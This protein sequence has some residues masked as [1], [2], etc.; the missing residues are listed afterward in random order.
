MGVLN[1]LGSSSQIY[2]SLRHDWQKRTVTEVLVGRSVGV[3]VGGGGVWSPY[4]V[5]WKLLVRRSIINAT[6]LRSRS[7]TLQIVHG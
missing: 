2:E 3:I 1:F 7:E 6:V 4:C 5:I